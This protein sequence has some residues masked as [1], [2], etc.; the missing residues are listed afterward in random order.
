MAGTKA[1][2]AKAAI[3]AALQALTGPSQALENVLVAYIYPG[4]RLQLENVYGGRIRFDQELSTFASPAVGGGRQPRTE[5]A[6]ITFVVLV[7]Y[8]DHDQQKADERAAAIGTVLEE[9][10]AAN[11][12][13]GGI[14]QV[15]T[16][17]SG[18]IEPFQDDDAV[19]A[20]LT[21]NVSVQSELI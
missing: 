13:L 10:L 4:K 5:R 2:A 17:E 8:P 18:D 12:L 1:P 14:A 6:T 11:P 7:K 3:I 19:Y 20:Q 15:A 16:I 9:Y 21:Y